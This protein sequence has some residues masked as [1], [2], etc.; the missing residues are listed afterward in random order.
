[1]ETKEPTA[2]TEPTDEERWN[3]ILAS[4]ARTSDAIARRAVVM[5]T[6]PDV[7][8]SLMKQPR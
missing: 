1:M 6:L 4:M 3:A 8:P 5:S 2:A 7:M